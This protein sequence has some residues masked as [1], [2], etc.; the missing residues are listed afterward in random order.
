MRHPAEPSCAH[1]PLPSCPA[2]ALADSVPAFFFFWNRVVAI[3]PSAARPALK[4]R[5]AG[6]HTDWR[7]SGCG[8]FPPAAATQKPREG[9]HRLPPLAS[10]GGPCP[11][12][13]QRPPWSA[14]RGA[15]CVPA[16]G[17]AEDPRQPTSGGGAGGGRWARVAATGSAV[18]TG[19]AGGCT[20]SRKERSPVAGM[21]MQWEWG[22]RCGVWQGPPPRRRQRQRQAP[23]RKPPFHRGRAS[24]RGDTGLGG[25]GAIPAGMRAARSRDWLEGRG[26]RPPVP[27]ALAFPAHA[28]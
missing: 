4:W 6:P 16:T 19:G 15:A 10:R 25:G 24:A 23:T 2:I 20:C 28:M 8:G 22:K 11:R 18:A 21:G 9:V 27:L 5:P 12:R 17:A 3:L 26:T 1:K 14:V 13:S 7:L